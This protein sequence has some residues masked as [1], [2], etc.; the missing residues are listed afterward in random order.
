LLSGDIEVNFQ[1]D[2][3]ED[4]GS[5]FTGKQYRPVIFRREAKP[6][7]IYEIFMSFRRLMPL[8]YRDM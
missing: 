8:V 5:Q 6:P 7:P 4:H 3:C 1:V 2:T